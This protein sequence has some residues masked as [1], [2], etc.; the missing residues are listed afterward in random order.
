[1]S[2][3]VV[4]IVW[5]FNLPAMEKLV[6]LCLADH[7]H[8]DGA[9]CFPSVP[10]IAVRTA[11]SERGVQKILRRLQALGIITA[12]VLGGGRKRATHWRIALRWP[13]EERANRVHRFH[14]DQN[15]QTVNGVHAKGRTADRENGEPRSPE[16]SLNINKENQSVLSRRKDFDSD[17]ESGARNGAKLA[18]K[19]LQGEYQDARA[20]GFDG[21][22]QQWL[23]GESAHD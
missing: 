12:Y 14:N 1:M 21:T 8:E 15:S 6:L 20:R 22:F 23:I 3:Q 7:A 19:G 10:R 13:G 16:S 2:W 17:K 4:K 9:G 18:S 5:G 11:L